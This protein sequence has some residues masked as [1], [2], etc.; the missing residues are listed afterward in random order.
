[1]QFETVSFE[2]SFCCYLFKFIAQ[3]VFYYGCKH[4]FKRRQILRTRKTRVRLAVGKLNNR[5]C[6]SHSNL[7]WFEKNWRTSQCCFHISSSVKSYFGR[8]LYSFRSSLSIESNFIRA[9]YCFISLLLSEL[10]YRAVN[11]VYIRKY[12]FN[13]HYVI[14]LLYKI[15][16]TFIKKTHFS[17][18]V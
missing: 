9:G 6:C 5:V 17:R 12:G 15:W 4:I 13:S 18:S 2:H 7:N 11:I 1:M 10:V 14:Y 8:K 3:H 16:I